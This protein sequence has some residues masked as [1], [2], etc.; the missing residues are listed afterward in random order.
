MVVNLCFIQIEGTY[1]INLLS[2]LGLVNFQQR[3]HHNT[4]NPIGYVNSILTANVFV[5]SEPLMSLCFSK[6]FLL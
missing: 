4:C 2:C 6:M 5:L 1:I 3:R